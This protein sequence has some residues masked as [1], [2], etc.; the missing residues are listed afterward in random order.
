LDKDDNVI[1][2]I[3]GTLDEARVVWLSN[4][5]V[6]ISAIMKHLKET[7][8]V[9]TNPLGLT[10]F[11]PAYTDNRPFVAL[12]S[13]KQME[14][15]SEPERAISARAPAVPPS[16]PIE[17]HISVNGSPVFTTSAL[18]SRPE[19]S[20]AQETAEFEK[21]LEDNQDFTNCLGYQ[22]EFLDDRIPI[23]IPTEKLRKKLAFL[24]DNPSTCLLKYHH[25]STMQHSLRRVPVVSAINVS[26]KYRYNALGKDT[27]KDNWLR[28]N[29]IDYDAQLDDKW[30][31]KS[32][33][34]KGHLSRREDAE[35]GRSMSAAKTAADMTCSYA[36]A[37]PQVPALNR[38]IFGHHG[39]WGILEQNLLE[40]GI[41]L[42]N[43]KLSRISIFAGP[44][45]DDD[46]PVYASV[47]IALRFFK[48]VAWYKDSGTLQA[49]AFC[50]SQEKLVD[51]IEFEVLRF[52][53]LLKTEQKPITWI[54]EA[55]GLKFPNILKSAD[56]YRN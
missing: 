24:K 26:G 3:Q 36:N 28:D 20:A 39:K 8:T 29:R 49:T 55:T 13:P 12:S 53:E 22:A 33:F 52:D 47:Q 16:A 45:F 41:K 34:D 9:A 48:I 15:E 4:R 2:V 50:L 1:P 54:E 44:L 42:E 51:Q 11:S 40:Q 17:I 19:L 32:G 27:R 6:R 35:W 30:Y 31:A 37:A 23:P 5:G 10:F 46:D 21:K 18:A 56:T 7:P 43:G 38:A 14:T 25:Y